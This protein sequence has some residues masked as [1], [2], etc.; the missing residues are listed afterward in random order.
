MFQNTGKVRS[1]ELRVRRME[2][3]LQHGALCR[4]LFYEPATYRKDEMPYHSTLSSLGVDAH[5]SACHLE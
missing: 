5:T 3:S 4:N 1:W 2:L